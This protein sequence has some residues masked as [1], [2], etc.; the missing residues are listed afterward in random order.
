VAGVVDH[1]GEL[2]PALQQLADPVE[3]GWIAAHVSRPHTPM[4][5]ASE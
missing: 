3:S 4:P 1:V 5:R 2:D